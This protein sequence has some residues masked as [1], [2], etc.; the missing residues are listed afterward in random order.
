M[1][2]EYIMEVYRESD[3]KKLAEFICNELKSLFNF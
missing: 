2:V 1:S 3:D